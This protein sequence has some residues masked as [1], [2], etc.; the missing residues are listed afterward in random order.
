MD[1]Q[2]VFNQDLSEKARPGAVFVIELLFREP[3]EL[4]DRENMTAVMQRRVGNVECFWHDEKGAGFAAKDYLAQFKDGSVPPQL[5]VMNC[6]DFDGTT[7]GTFERSQMWDCINDKD[8]ILDECKYM[9]CATDM[10]AAVLEAQERATLDMD[11]L[12]A[13]VELFPTCEAVLI[14]DSGKLLPADAIRNHS[15]PRE[16]RFVKFAVNAR[17]FNIQGTE[18]MMVD[19]LGMGTLYL[20]DLQYHFHG[21]D[22]NWVVQHAYTIADYI[23]SND[24][25]IKPGDSI[26]GI[27]NGRFTQEVMW[28]CHY[29][30]A[31]IQPVREV[32][33]I[34]MN[35]FASGKRE[36]QESE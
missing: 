15:V 26:D 20:P 11:F 23:L 19:T 35:E 28:R 6:T 24:N 5:M 14:L 2:E 30:D 7:I 33:D 21:M 32:I 16:H 18:D 10:M 4:P 3:V 9:V 1:N 22:P 31:L 34:Y 8:R 17:F 25:P 27:I 12:E 29:E 13:L 36:N